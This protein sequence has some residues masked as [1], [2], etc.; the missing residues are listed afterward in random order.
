[1]K[2][3]LLFCI[4]FNLLIALPLKKIDDSILDYNTKLLWQDTISN[5]QK[6]FTHQE[7]IRYCKNIKL[8]GFRGWRLP[9]RA[10]Y[11]TILDMNRE[12][13]E[14]KVKKIFKYVLPEQYWT[15]D[16]TWLRNFGLYSYYIIFKS[17]AFYYQNRTYKKYV[18]CV[19]TIK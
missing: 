14:P 9:T 16:R 7:A 10:E 6:V 2:Q 18:K 12:D 1:M 13:E 11:K 15:N 5:T 8:R 3:L 4:S 19:H 17:G